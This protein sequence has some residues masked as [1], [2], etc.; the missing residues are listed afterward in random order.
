MYIYIR[1]WVQLKM[2]RCVEGKKYAHGWKLGVEL[3]EKKFLKISSDAT[4]TVVLKVANQNQSS[5]TTDG[6][7]IQRT[8]YRWVVKH[9]LKQ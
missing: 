3:H 1:E 7:L 8:V 9:F 2:I 6:P 5:K 4:S